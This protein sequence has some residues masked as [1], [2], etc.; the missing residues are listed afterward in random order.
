MKQLHLIQ[1]QDVVTHFLIVYGSLYVP[2]NINQSVF[3]GIII[4]NSFSGIILIDVISADY[5]IE[6]IQ[7]KLLTYHIRQTQNTFFEA[8]M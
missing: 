4:K 7:H 3:V 8:Y 5:L 6:Y 2:C 1:A